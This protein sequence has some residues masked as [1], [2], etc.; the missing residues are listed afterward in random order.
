[1][2]KK[3]SNQPTKIVRE[4]NEE[5]LDAMKQAMIKESR[6]PNVNRALLKLM[7]FTPEKDAALK[8]LTEI[9]VHCHD[10]YYSKKYGI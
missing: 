10:E 6:D 2:S 3:K 8:A 5:I 7:T 9:M 1:M 4:S